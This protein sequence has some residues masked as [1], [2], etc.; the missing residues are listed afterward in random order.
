MAVKHY[1][2]IKRFCADAGYRKSFGQDVSDQLDFG[3]DIPERIKPEWNTL[4]KRWVVERSFAWFNDS[5]RLS[6]DYEIRRVSN[7]VDNV[8]AGRAF[9]FLKEKEPKRTFAETSFPYGAE[10]LCFSAPGILSKA[11]GC[12]GLAPAFLV[13]LCK[14][15]LKHASFNGSH[16]IF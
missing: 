2:S 12:C 4:P 7:P 3:V 13:N 14:G 15:I 6:K 9:L 1:S 16:Y 10:K 11:R 8:L 5:R